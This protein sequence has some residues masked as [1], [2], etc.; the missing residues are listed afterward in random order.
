MTDHGD[1]SGRKPEDAGEREEKLHVTK[2]TLADLDAKEWEKDAG[3]VKGGA[4][5][6]QTG[7]CQQSTW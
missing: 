4:R 1:E 3:A 7:S 6:C 5:G 2:E